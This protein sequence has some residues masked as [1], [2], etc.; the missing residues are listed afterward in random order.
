MHDAAHD[1]GGRRLSEQERDAMVAA[2]LGVTA[3]RLR[4]MRR[5]HGK[6]GPV[7]GGGPAP[8]WRCID[9]LDDHALHDALRRHELRARTAGRSSLAPPGD[10]PR[11]RTARPR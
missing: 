5:V 4:T 6:R 2:L 3:E 9:E 11:R 10:R 7:E 8:R 1:A